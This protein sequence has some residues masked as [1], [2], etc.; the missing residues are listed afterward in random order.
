MLERFQQMVKT[1]EIY[2]RF[3][4]RPGEARAS[5]DKF[6]HRCSEAPVSGTGAAERG[7]AITSAVVYVH[8]RAVGLPKWQGWVRAAREKSQK[9]SDRDHFRLLAE[10]APQLPA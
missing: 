1:E 2:W 10:P 3:C 5:L 9:M 8:G 7:D 6:R 4:A